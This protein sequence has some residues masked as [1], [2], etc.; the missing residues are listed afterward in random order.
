MS[1]RLPLSAW[2]LAFSLIAGAILLIA[3]TVRAD[4]PPAP[5][6]TA[7]PGTPPAMP[8]GPPPSLAQALAEAEP[9]QEDLLLSVDAEKVGLP[10]EAAPPQ[11]GEEAAVTAQAYGR[12]TQEFGAVTAIAPP[13]MTLLNTQP[14]T[15]NPYD[16]MPPTDALKMLLGTL[17]DAQWKAL[18][19]PDGLGLSSLGS[20]SQRA[21]LQAAFPGESLTLHP[22]RDAGGP[23]GWDHLPKMT[24]ADLGQATLRLGQRVMVGI[25]VVGKSEWMN[26]PPEEAGG[27][28]GYEVY[29]GDDGHRKDTLYGVTV[30]RDAPNALKPSD[31]DFDAKKWEQPVKTEGVKTVGD[32]IAR[33][34]L[35]AQTELYADR[36]YEKRT[37]L[38]IGAKSRPAPSARAKDL[39]RALALCVAGAYRKVGPAYILTNDILGV[40]T[41]RAILSRFA[42]EA[43]IARHAALSEAADTF[44]R[45]HGGVDDLPTLEGQR[46]FSDA[47]KAQAAKDKPYRAMGQGM[48]FQAPLDQLTP[49]QQDTARRF[50]EQWEASHAA[51]PAQGGEQ[52]EVTLTG[53]LLLMSQPMFLLQSP[54][55]PG[56]VSLD[57]Y[58]NVWDLFHPSNKLE[59]EMR[60][61]QA[62]P[63]VTPPQD[64]APPKRAAPPLASLL[65]RIPRRA[66]VARPRTA[67]EVDA[68]VV[69]LQVIHLNQLWLDVFSEGKPHLDRGKDD[70]PDILTEALAR[71]KGTG[72]QVIPTLDLL[73]WTG[74]APEEAR[75]LTMLGE[76]SAQAAAHRRRAEAVLYQGLTADEADKQP[77][78]TDLSVS[79]VAP[80][81]RQTL[82]ALVRRLAATRGVAAL[83]LRETVTTGYDRPADSRYGVQG[84]ALGYTPFLRLA[85]LRKDHVDPLDLEPESYDGQMNADLSLPDFE[86][87]GDLGNASQDWNGF[88]AGADLDLLQTLLAAAQQGAG[89]RLPFL[90]KQRR[91]GWRSSWYGLWDDPRARLPELS[92]EMAFG[93]SDMD[94]SFAGFAHAQSRINLYEM[95]RWAAQSK[96]GLAAALQQIKPGWDGIVLDFSGDMKG[97]PLAELAKGLAPPAPKPAPAHP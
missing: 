39:L 44:I 7:A 62:P 95:Y 46:A 61:K 76:T 87:W 9:S 19:G 59:Q 55:L 31:L 96:D 53:K 10:K 35:T 4:D 17:T 38:L 36:R 3:G 58:F 71:T 8:A 22:R 26:S 6:A 68:L 25:P 27:K 49:P 54:T 85:F 78:S 74:D 52:Q 33:I 5:A 28:P 86:G 57:S 80:Q 48:Q 89:R 75:D 24:R 63:T 66:V 13:T 16:G 91:S 72:I 43:D 94:T 2:P 77:A 15:P 45:A 50:V 30:R 84:D 83:A 90:I 21:L 14:G 81:V 65:A 34:G 69:S 79:P 18:T 60:Q 41:R 97:D 70:A 88:R 93:P 29:G 73:K 51:A 40:G 37:V 12:I 67:Q 92:E 1:R 64:T 32:L 23:V 82:T 20:D 11:K 42:Q 47:Q 56:A